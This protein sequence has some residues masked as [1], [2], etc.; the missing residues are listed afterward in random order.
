[1][2]FFYNLFLSS[3]FLFFTFIA[4][5]QSDLVITTEV[6]DNTGGSEVRLTGPWWGWDPAGGPVAADNGDGTYTFTFSPAPTDNMEYLLV[7]DGVQEDMVAAGTASG[8]W[9]CTPITDYANYAN[10]QWLISDPS[11]V[12]NV[13]GQ[14]GPCASQPQGLTITTEVCGNTG[15]SEV[16]LTGP[17]WGWDPAGGPVA[18]DNGDGTYTFTFSPAPAD[19]M[20][21]LLVLDGVQ[22]DMVAAGTESGDWSCTP[23]TDYANY[24]NR[25]WLTSDPT[26][27]SNVYGQCS[28]CPE[29]PVDLVITTEICDNTGGSEVRLTGPW[30]GWDPAGG[31]VAVDNGDGTYTFTFSP[32]P[33]DNMEYLLV[34]DG[35]QEDMV[36]A[37]TA[38]EDWSCT[39]ITDYANYANRQW[40]TTDAPTVSNVYGRC[41]PCPLPDLVITTEVCGNLGGSEV[42]L[43]GPWWGWDPAG[44]PVAADNGDGTYTFTF[45]PAPSDNM[46]YL[47]VLDGVQEDMVAAGI[48]SEDWSCT[49]IT[50]Y[51]NYAN[52]QW[53]TSEPATFSNVYGQCGPCSTVNLDELTSNSIL[54]LY[55]N[56]ATEVI[57]FISSDEIESIQ[58]FN[59]SGKIM[60]N[61]TV[62]NQ[63]INIQ[64][65]ETGMYYVFAHIN[66]QILRASFVKI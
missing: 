12:S 38:S 57:K 4:F 25:Q 56:P 10:R 23:I 30:W 29:E 59:L 6:C 39:P 46:E 9:S 20:E 53:L 36:A 49:P 18:S 63:M 15:G 27:I 40:L 34:L 7:L 48:A 16:R 28:P 52:R 62:S 8:D 43:T 2:K 11:A 66:G 13:Y 17:W 44:G 31:P 47:L 54:K 33:T 55:P 14:C 3:L 21:Y 64:N 60:N 26:T 58:V 1:M 5:S 61:I 51:A 41:S 19:N 24:A 45:S 42:R 50:D 22:E 32:A 37:G 35:V 65:L